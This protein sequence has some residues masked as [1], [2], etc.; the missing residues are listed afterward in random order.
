[1]IIY[2]FDKNTNRIEDKKAINLDMFCFVGII[3]MIFYISIVYGW[4]NELVSF[5][6]QFYWVI[7]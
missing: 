7:N 2:I 6:L 5:Y 1:M 4:K 3:E